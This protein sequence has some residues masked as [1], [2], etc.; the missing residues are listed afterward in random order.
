M[1]P[2]SI[3]NKNILIDI[4]YTFEGKELMLTLSPVTRTIDPNN[5]NKYLPLVDEREVK[6]QEWHNILCR[7]YSTFG[8]KFQVESLEKL[9]Q[10]LAEISANFPNVS[11]DMENL[12]I[13]KRIVNEKGETIGIAGNVENGELV[14]EWLDSTWLKY[15]EKL[16]ESPF[17]I[18]MLTKESP[19]KVKPVV[20]EKLD[21]SE[22]VKPVEVNQ[23]KIQNM[24][25]KA[26]ASKS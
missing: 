11:V 17:N 1:T 12:K 14:N 26:L 9:P 10:C 18:T 19:V 25:K 13:R 21:F 16:N 6:L 24:V 2:T 20:A 8:T 7:Q 23:E 3:Q 22:L 5:P 15:R 4:A